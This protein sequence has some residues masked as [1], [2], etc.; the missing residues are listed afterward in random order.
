MAAEAQCVNRIENKYSPQT[1][2][3]GHQILTLLIFPISVG[4]CFSCY[5]TLV[6]L[7]TFL[8]STV[9]VLGHCISIQL[10]GA[11]STSPA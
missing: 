9:L 6:G 5:A 1:K 2:A 3:R 7:A 8:A 4:T 11:M 10:S